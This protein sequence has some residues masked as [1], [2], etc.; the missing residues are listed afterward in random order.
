MLPPKKCLQA[1]GEDGNCRSSPTLYRIELCLH[2]M[3]TAGVE[4]TTF[5]LTITIFYRRTGKKMMDGQG[6][7]AGSP[8]G[9]RF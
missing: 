7:K 2:K 5:R 3:E 9:E 8:K 4:P 6:R 1:R